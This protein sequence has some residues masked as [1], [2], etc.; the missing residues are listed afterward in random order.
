MFINPTYRIQSGNAHMQVNWKNPFVGK[1]NDLRKA[2]SNHAS[3]VL[4]ARNLDTIFTI[5]LDNVAID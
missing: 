1:D 2:S 5:N 4:K 3:F